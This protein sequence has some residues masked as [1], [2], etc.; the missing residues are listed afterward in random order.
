MSTLPPEDPPGEPNDA[1]PAPRR[2]RA[3]AKRRRRAAKRLAGLTPD[4]AALADPIGLYLGGYP[5][6]LRERAR[7][8]VAEEKLSAYLLERYPLESCHQHRSDSQLWSFVQTLKRQHL[9]NA[10]PL[11]KIRYDARLQS[12]Q[13]ALGIHV[14]AS[15]VQGGKLKAKRELLVDQLFRSA[16]LAFLKMIVAHELAHLRE[17]DHN[18]AFYQ[19]CELIEPD[20]HQLEFDLRLYLVCRAKGALI[21]PL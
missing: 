6:R 19:L 9:R 8:L 5:E 12:A 21:Y 7:G 15:R 18:R 2:E 16:P 14:S 11:S 3:A 20:Y 13:R 17:R 4:S 1:P 10:P